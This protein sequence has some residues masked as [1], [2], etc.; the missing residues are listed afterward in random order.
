M[1]FDNYEETLKNIDIQKSCCFT[2]S[3]AIRG[4]DIESLG[5]TICKQIEYLIKEKNIKYFLCGGAV[6]FDSVAGFSVI[7]SR[8]K[9]PFI[10]LILVLP[11]EDHFARWGNNNMRAFDLLQSNADFKISCEATYTIDCM[12]TRNRCLVDFSDYCIYYKNNEFS[13][14]TKYTLN[15]AVLNNK[16]TI[17]IMNSLQEDYPDDYAQLSF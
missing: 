17:N 16:K 7:N 6:G 3:R 9:Y 11:C 12:R 15:Y 8:G 1:L 10:K 4:V 14:G 13:K 5:I 2:G